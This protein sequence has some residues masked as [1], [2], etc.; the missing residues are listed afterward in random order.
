MSKNTN[1][2]NILYYLKASDLTNAKFNYLKQKYNI[3]DSELAFMCYYN[4]KINIKCPQF[5]KYNKKQQ[6]TLNYP[7]KYNI[8]YKLFLMRHGYYVLPTS[9]IIGLFT[10]LYLKSNKKVK[11][12]LIKQKTSSKVSYSKVEPYVKLL[13]TIV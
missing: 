10:I 7:I 2:N 6:S 12:S 11:K 13:E 5:W 8:L 1:T 4:K 9:F 3:Q